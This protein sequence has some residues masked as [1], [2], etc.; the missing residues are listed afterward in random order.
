MNLIALRSSAFRLYYCGNVAAV[1][2]MWILQILLI[3][4]AW[5]VTGSASFV[6]MIGAFALFPT[7]LSGPLFGVAVDRMNIR[8]AAYCTNLGMVLVA[9]TLL[10]VQGT[11]ALDPVWLSAIAAALGIVKSAH[12]PV[13]LSMGP[14]LVERGHVASVVALTSLNFNLA[15]IVAPIFAG[16]SIEHAGVTPTLVVAVLLYVPTFVILAFL[17][18]RDTREHGN[19]VSFSS[20]FWQGL[21]YLWHKPDLRAILFLSFLFALAIR[22]VMEVLPVV[23]DGQFARGATGVG[24]LG[25]AIGA[26]ALVAALIKALG[27]ADDRGI[28]IVTLAS[29]ALGV[30]AVAAFGNTEV[31]G[32]VMVSAIVLGFTSTTLGVSL[33]TAIQSDLP[34]DLRGRVMSIWIVVG[35]GGAALGS[36]VIGALSDLI[37]FS[38]ATLVMSGVSLAGLFI[39]VASGSVEAKRKG[40]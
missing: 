23:A 36:L 20:A 5:D 31:W 1:N 19:S 29:A 34:D 6:G 25:S 4:L 12:H 16:F 22:G 39:L 8:I 3:W 30:L 38:Q 37:G 21:A 10:A 26:G 9:L 40:G 2:G 17:H 11:G 32:L 7:V 27:R 24:Q 14:R 35:L 33:Q 18:P 13:R 28:S 15:R